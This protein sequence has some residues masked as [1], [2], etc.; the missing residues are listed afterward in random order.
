MGKVIKKFGI[1]FNSEGGALTL[2]PSEVRER[3]YGTGEFTRTHED[4]WTIKGLVAEDWYEWV[5]DFEASHPVYG[6]VSGNFETEVVADSEEGFA[7]F[8]ENHTPEA[9]DYWDI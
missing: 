7:H 3:D 8:Y 4:G 9:W 6:K 2:D 5:N 1:D